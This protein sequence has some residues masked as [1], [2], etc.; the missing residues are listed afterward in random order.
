MK[1]NK[2]MS[3]FLVAV[4][5][6]SLLTG[7]GGKEPETKEPETKEPA[8]GVTEV[9]ITED[10][11]P[12]DSAIFDG[13]KEI[14]TE[15]IAE[16]TETEFFVGL[17]AEKI[18]SVS[19]KNFV[20]CGL[21]GV[22]YRDDSG[23]YGILTPD[24]KQ[25][26]GAKYTSCKANG[27]YFNVTTVDSTTVTGIYS[28]NCMGLVDGTGKELI[29]MQYAAI[30]K[31]SDRFFQ[32]MTV[33]EET[34]NRDEALLY[35][36]D[37]LFSITASED[38]TLFKGIW[39]VYDIVAGKLVEGVSA[40]NRYAVHGYGNFIDYV[41]DDEN[42]ICVNYRGEKLPNGVGVYD[43]FDNGYYS[44][45]N[46]IYD[47]DYK[48]VFDYD[49]QGFVPYKGAGNYFISSKRDV[50][51]KRSYALMDLTGKIISAEYSDF[52]YIYGE[53]VCVSGEVY[54]FE[55]KKIIEGIYDSVYHEGVLA[56]VW[57]LKSG[58]EHTLIN[59]NGV[60][61]WQG[62]AGNEIKIETNRFLFSKK[63][64]VYSRLFYSFAE[65]DFTLNGLSFAYWLLEVD[66][67]N[68]TYDVVDVISGKT[69]ISG[70]K[71]YYSICDEQSCIYVYALNPN[72][73][74]DI[75]KVR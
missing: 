21:G 28:Y 20:Q 43:V 38:D 62:A 24:G 37:A 65:K 69:I 39:H 50:N 30:K 54:N 51:G 6:L 57:L 63:G 46:G 1:R 55:G 2:C 48:K 33:T 56:N 72:D 11:E 59:K 13:E 47:A 12:T 70:Y 42:K 41:N 14:P 68:A 18:G 15:V 35:V 7:C 8:T 9:D 22:V 16:T 19:G 58:N 64:D 10:T 29:P 60:V 52:P 5:I 73:G 71:D 31:I 40:T 74:F 53:L 45:N 66:A 34:E 75:Y 61:L 23:K 49:P 17:S 3:M 36:T 26:T 27:L 44:F 25:D 32:V 4:M 67:P